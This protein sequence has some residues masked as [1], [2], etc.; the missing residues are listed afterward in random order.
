MLTIEQ[1]N[2][3]ISRVRCESCGRTPTPEWRIE[4]R[5]NFGR[6][7]SSPTQKLVWFCPRCMESRKTPQ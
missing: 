1:Q 3:V 4:M 7:L 5:L 6:K 2:A